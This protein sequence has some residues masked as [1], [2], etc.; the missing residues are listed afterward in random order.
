MTKFLPNI[1]RAFLVYDKL[2]RA[3]I[4][5]C[6]KMANDEMFENL[7]QTSGLLDKEIKRWR[8]KILISCLFS[9]KILST[10]QYQIFL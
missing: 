6:C 2:I 4:L 5:N 8:Y 10:Y 3:C 7:L 9:Q 1:N